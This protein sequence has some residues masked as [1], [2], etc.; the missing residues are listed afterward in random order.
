MT[1]YT[2]QFAQTAEQGFLDL[3]SGMNNIIECQVSASE[4]GSLIA[5][6]AVK[7]ED[8]AGGLPKVLALTA[9]TDA[10]FG[11]VVYN[12]KDTSFEA[13]ESLSVAIKGTVM[14]MVAG[15]AIARG[16]AVE[17]VYTTKKVITSAGINPRVGFALDKAAA[18]GDLIRV[19]VET[20]AVVQPI[21]LDSLND[22]TLSS[23]SN[24][25][26]LKFNGTAW[27]NAA[28]AT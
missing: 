13:K 22:V 28:D 7:M 6:E 9:N 14:W 1:Q 5:G 27:V 26:V 19:Y 10:T 25:Q 12:G 24:T 16:A 4:S 21:T 3:Q 20:P 8:S 15:A 17:V 11:F 23:P 2:N 18:D